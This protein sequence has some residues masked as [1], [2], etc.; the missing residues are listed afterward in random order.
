MGHGQ[1]PLKE[2]LRDLRE[3]KYGETITI[4][5]DFDNKKRNDIENLKQASRELEKSIDFVRKYT[6]D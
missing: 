1:L 4:E 6:R 2:L 5:L 3:D